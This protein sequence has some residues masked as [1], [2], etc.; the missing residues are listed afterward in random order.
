[1]KPEI[2]IE[3]IAKLSRLT[4]DEGESERLYKDLLA[5][6]DF[7]G[8]LPDAGPYDGEAQDSVFR[9]DIPK[10]CLSREELLS[11]AP[12]RTEEFFRVPRTVKGD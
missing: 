11:N 3:K 6:I 4:L 2:S 1:M 7:A 9:E 8:K 5:M 12:D 10:S